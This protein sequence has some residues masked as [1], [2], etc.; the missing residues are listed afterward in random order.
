MGRDVSQD[1]PQ[2]STS[3]PHLL[4]PE[5][6]SEHARSAAAR[7]TWTKEVRATSTPYRPGASRWTRRKS[8][9]PKGD[10]ARRF[11]EPPDASDGPHRKRWPRASADRRHRGAICA[12]ADQRERAPSKENCGHPD[13]FNALLVKPSLIVADL[14][15]APQP[16][17]SGPGIRSGGPGRGR[18]V[19]LRCVFGRRSNR[20]I[21]SL[22][23]AG[24]TDTVPPP[25]LN[26]DRIGS[27]AAS[28]SG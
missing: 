23:A 2:T 27:A 6:W 22:H 14:S 12:H 7:A 13:D 1:S 9:S 20:V 15:P 4:S 26:H 19:W 3:D 24:A 28:K 18:R 8:P 21:R 16:Q 17:I 5:I 11:R 25:H 10:L